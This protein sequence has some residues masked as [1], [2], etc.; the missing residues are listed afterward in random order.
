MAWKLRQAK[1]NVWIGDLGRLLVNKGGKEASLKAVKDTCS[2]SQP[3]WF[4]KIKVCQHLILQAVLVKT[5]SHIKGQS[6]VWLCV[7]KGAFLAMSWRRAAVF[8]TCGH[9]GEP[10]AHILVLRTWPGLCEAWGKHVTQTHW[11][12][13]KSLSVMWA[14]LIDLSHF[15]NRS[16][17]YFIA[18]ASGLSTGCTAAGK[19]GYDPLEKAVIESSA[20]L[21]V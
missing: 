16:F 15:T 19:P 12:F 14:A 13:L 20:L 8:L 17:Y 5:Q 4:T 11:G 3:T 18:P 7:S 9:P 6:L 2:V 21:P 10:S 1:E